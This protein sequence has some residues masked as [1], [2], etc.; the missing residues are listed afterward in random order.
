MLVFKNNTKGVLA[1][2]WGKDRINRFGKRCFSEVGPGKYNIDAR[3]KTEAV[4]NPAVGF[5]SKTVR[6]IFDTLIY[7]TRNNKIL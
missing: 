3:H 4:V 6:S 5:S 7:N 2:V 1:G